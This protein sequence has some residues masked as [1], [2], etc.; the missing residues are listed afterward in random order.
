VQP[1]TLTIIGDLF[2]IQQRAKIQGITSSVWGVASIG[3]PILG[4]LITDTIG[5]RF[6]FF[7][8]VPFGVTS[9]VLLYRY[10]HAHPEKHEHVLAYLGTALLSGSILSLLLGLLQGVTNYGWTGGPTLFAFALAAGLLALFI[11]REGKAE[12]PV[13]PLWLF[14]NRIIAI[15]S[16]ISF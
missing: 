12:E 16:L 13:L 1:V 11:Y 14:R 4:G 6:V 10:F 5:W 2:T 3:G 9:I 8:N 7:V 15:A